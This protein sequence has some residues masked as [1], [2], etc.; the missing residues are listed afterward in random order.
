[1]NV[2]DRIKLSGKVALVT[3]GSRGL[4]LG[5]DIAVALSQAGAEVALMARREKYF[6]EARAILAVD[7]E[8]LI[9]ISSHEAISMRLSRHI[10]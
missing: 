10:C 7:G 3:R 1:M 6:D 8:T 2:F 4:G 9:W 5:L